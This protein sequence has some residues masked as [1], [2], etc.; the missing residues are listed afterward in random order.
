MA[1]AL[2]NLYFM[3]LWALAFAAVQVLTHAAVLWQFGFLDP[4]ARTL[5][6]IAA[7]FPGHA[8]TGFVLSLFFWPARSMAVRIMAMIPLALVLFFNLFAFHYHAMFAVLPGWSVLRYLEEWATVK[9]SL[10]VEAPFAWFAGTLVFLI[11]ALGS[12][13]WLLRRQSQK[14]GP[15]PAVRAW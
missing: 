9:T 11:A 6:K 1:P 5:L 4:S 15:A 2:R 10:R 12:L 7:G 13:L 3:A 14:N 8:V